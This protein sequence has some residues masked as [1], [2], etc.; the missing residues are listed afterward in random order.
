LKGSWALPVLF[1]ITILFL[2][3][4]EASAGPPSVPDKVTDL[5]LDGISGNQ[6]DLSWTIPFDGGSPITGY[7][8]QSKV[9]GVISTIET[10]FGGATTSTYSDT[11]LTTGDDVTYRIAAINAL[12]QG[13]YSNVPP[14]VITSG[15]GGGGTVPDAVTGLTLSVISGST[16]NL[17]WTIPFDG[18]SPITGFQILQFGYLPDQIFL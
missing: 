7:K 6:V 10:S 17:D 11:S 14:S 13:P 15:G 3:V 4:N 12:G 9:N 2:A 16:V 8:I 1:S 18:G 5:T